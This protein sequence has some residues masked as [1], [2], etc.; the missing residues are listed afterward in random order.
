MIVYEVFLF[1]LFSNVLLGE[2]NGARLQGGAAPDPN[3][4]VGFSF[5]RSRL[6]LVPCYDFYIYQEEPL[7]RDRYQKVCFILDGCWDKQNPTCDEWNRMLYCCVAIMQNSRCRIYRGRLALDN[8]RIFKQKGVMDM[9]GLGYS[10]QADYVSYHFENK[11]DIKCY[12][13]STIQGFEYSTN[14]N[15]PTVIKGNTWFVVL[16]IGII[17]VLVSM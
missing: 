8:W 4:V 7:T 1:F 14:T 16:A 2:S 9:C 15:Q 5:D 17:P 11:H 6:D 10:P 3:S 12:N 13:L